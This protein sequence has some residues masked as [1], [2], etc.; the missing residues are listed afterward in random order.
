L[1]GRLQLVVDGL[2]MNDAPVDYVD[3]DD[4]YRL[5]SMRTLRYL[6]LPLLLKEIP[7]DA[8]AALQ[9]AYQPLCLDDGSRRVARRFEFVVM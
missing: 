6:D 7:A 3:V 4:G 8:V 1:Y 9:K 2:E 5:W